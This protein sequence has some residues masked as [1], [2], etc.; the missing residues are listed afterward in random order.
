MAR[1]FPHPG[2]L[3]RRSAAT[4][5]MGLS[6][7]VGLVAA[8]LGLLQ[9]SFLR[10]GLLGY[11]LQEVEADVSISAVEGEWPTRLVLRDIRLHDSQGDW[12]TIAQLSLEWNPMALFRG[13]LHVP[14]LTLADVDLQR[15]PESEDTAQ[16]ESAFPTLPIPLRLDHFEITSLEVGESL[17]GRKAQLKAEGRLVW[18]RHF[19]DTLLEAERIDGIAGSLQAQALVDSGRRLANIKI[20]AADGGTSET[21]PVA[22]LTGER[23]YAPATL[24]LDYQARNG[25]VTGKMALDAGKAV[26]LQA[27]ARGRWE[28]ALAVDL[29]FKL[30]GQDVSTVFAGLGGAEEVSASGKLNWDEKD[31]LSFSAVSLTAGALALSGDVS[32]DRASRNSAH[33]VR[34]QG[35]FKGLEQILGINSGRDAQAPWQLE[36]VLSAGSSMLAVETFTLHSDLGELRLAGDLD[37]SKEVFKGDAVIVFSSLDGISE[38][39]GLPLTGKGQLGISP[40]SVHFNGEVAGDV[41]LRLGQ[42]ESRDAFVNGTLQG[43][44]NGDGSF[45]FSPEKGLS[46]PFFDLGG[47]DNKTRL[48]G[49]F[50]LSQTNTLGGK[51]TLE[52][53]ELAALS[54]ASLAGRLNAAA[55]FGGTTQKPR[56][57]FDARLEKGRLAGLDAANATLQG[58]IIPGGTGAISFSS[59]GRDGPF[60]AATRLTLPDAGGARLEA[61][62]L[63]GAGA[64][65]EGELAF[66]P[67]WLGEGRIEGKGQILRLVSVFSGLPVSGNADLDL[68]L[69]RRGGKQAARFS[70]TSPLVLLDLGQGLRLNKVQAAGTADDVFGPADIEASLKAESGSTGD[71]NIESLALKAGGPLSALAI[72]LALRGQHELLEPEAITLDAEAKFEDQR[73]RINQLSYAKAAQQLNLAKPLVI[74]L[75]KGVQFRALDLQTRAEKGEGNLQA[76]LDLRDRSAKLDARIR[77]FPLALLQPVLPV[78]YLQGALNGIVTLDTAR[79]TGKAQLSFTDISLSEMQQL[80]EPQL[81]AAELS[82][83][84]RSG[85]AET[86][87]HAGVNAQ[88]QLTLNASLP[89]LRDP[90]GAW[91]ILAKR[92]AVNASLSWQGPVTPVFA[93]LDSANQRL[94]G[95]AD[96]TL[97]MS[98]DISEPLING[99]ARIRN[100]SYE[101]FSSGTLLRQLELHARANRGETLSFTL[102]ANDAGSGKMTAE[103]NLSLA[104]SASPAIFLKANFAQARLVRRPELELSVSGEATLSGNKLPPDTDNPLTLW[105]KLVATQAN[106]RIPN[107][108]PASVAEID[109][110]EI[111]GPGKQ[112]AKEDPSV[113][114]LLLDVGLSIEKPLRVSGRGIDTLWRGELHAGGTIETPQ[115]TGELKSLQGSASFAGKTFAL[116][117]G[118]VKFPGGT[119]IDP[120]I[121]AL[122]SYSRSNLTANIIVSGRSSKPKINFTSEPQLPRDEI[123]ARILF[124]KGVGELTGFEAVQLATSL[125]ELS[126]SGLGGGGV[127]NS[128]QKS[129]GLD[130]LRI[131]TAKSGATTVTAGEYI[132]DK[133]YVGVEQGALAS[134]SSIKVEI[135]VTPQI[136]VDTKLGNDASGGAGINWRW[137]Y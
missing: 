89:V 50:S 67:D 92:G 59:T 29:A 12:L 102:T 110:I 93:L 134:D 46:I 64:T 35:L 137:D 58:E 55:T 121:D 86:S 72:T 82:S 21:S 71:M 53:S 116:K 39:A 126:G 66:S 2:L 127:L 5:L 56:I 99:D 107:N 43:K 44:L 7:G 22:L 41:A 136:T 69:L 97:T 128:L 62:T 101:H 26:T 28:R 108:M 54:P 119:P 11:A 122:L 100:G 109:V 23:N 73:L 1:V 129:I 30:A 81:I 104:A 113:F 74:D 38:I 40:F 78:D 17:A 88:R 49:T 130:V 61:L 4:A 115:L 51:A 120:D 79:G 114:P 18:S 32:V 118:A 112:S 133:V 132:G 98:G 13:E 36:G 125:A 31:R 57:A 6:L 42:I 96:M 117:R 60:K 68:Q 48:R 90:Q 3:A 70:L 14:E 87:F 111:N 19:L 124:D 85:R 135:E 47:A 37:F 10:Q 65:L 34:G 106:L 20:R 91:P 8:G 45:L 80:E 16:Q 131:D 27:D 52:I 94:N 77:N 24:S 33:A 63:N 84:W 123:F 83:E 25:D 15:M 105:G 95:D 9:I 76:D 103:G 75:S